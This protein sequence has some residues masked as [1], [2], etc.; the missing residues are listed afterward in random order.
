[1]NRG[2]GGNPQK[3]DAVLTHSRQAVDFVVAYEGL[4]QDPYGDCFAYSRHRLTA[5][6]QRY[7]P[8][9]GDG[10][11]LLDVGCGT[12]HHLAALRA[13][14]F[15]V[16]GVDASE[17]MLEHARRNN[18]GADVRLGDVEAL[19]LP[20]RQ[21]D[22]AI[23]IEVL[24]YLPS[25][26]ACLREAWRVLKPGGALL[27]TAAPLFNANGYYLVNRF[28]TR[29]PTRSLVRLRQFFLTE[30]RLRSAMKRAGFADVGVHGVYGGP[31]NWIER[32]APSILPR[33]LRRWEPWDAALSDRP[34]LRQFSNMF[35]AVGAKST[36]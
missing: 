8:E 1:V 26:E 25:C 5:A 10:L 4:A 34:L 32:L 16:T 17:A 29:I 2:R 13:R 35:L 21:F 28:A 31:I 14:G 3:R 19:P 7:L 30:G 27:V 20:D 18:P 12:G 9:R 15:D 24:R 23:C 6:L 33:L 11:R 22:I 36:P